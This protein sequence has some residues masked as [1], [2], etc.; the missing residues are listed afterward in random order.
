MPARSTACDTAG[1]TSVEIAGPYDVAGL[2]RHA[3][4][5]ADLRLPAAARARPRVT[6]RAAPDRSCTTLA[7]RAYRRPVDGR[8][9]C[10]ADDVLQAARRERRHV[11]RRHSAARSRGSSSSPQFLFRIERDPRGPARRARAYRVSDL[12][13]ASRLSFFLWSSIPD[14]ELLTLAEPRQ[15]AASR[16]VLE[17]AGAADARRS[18]AS[19]RSS[20]TSP[21]SGCSCATC[22]QSRPDADV[23]P[24]F[25]DNLR[26][27]FRRETELFFD[28]IMR[29]D[30]SVLDLL[31]RRLHV[32][33]RAAGAA[34]RHP[35]HLR[36][37]LPARDA[38]RRPARAACS[39]RAAS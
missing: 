19:T 25:D 18:R 1:R 20:A 34:L 37:P 24:D 14:D 30:R 22:R 11:R 7:R 39:A 26:Q 10:S 29:E 36:Q 12:E 27:A 38:H 4:P 23:F 21:G 17:R 15:A 13:L 31:T 5:A 2:R 28:S 16:R 35:E 8:R 6:T 32:R 9:T 3:E 33:Q